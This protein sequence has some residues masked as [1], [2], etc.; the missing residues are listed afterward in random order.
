MTAI[1][2]VNYNKYEDTLACVDS[3]FKSETNETYHIIVVDN[4]S[5]NDSWKRL[6]VLNQHESISLLL[7]DDNRGYCAGNNIGIKYALE[8]LGADY[9]WILNPDTLVE[10]DTLQNLHDFAG[11]KNDLGI[12]GCKLVYY[13]DT[14]YLQALG[15]GDFGVHKY[16]ELRPGAH[17]Y[18]L[19]SSDIDLPDEVELDLI[20]GASM[21]IPAKIFQTCGLMNE[22][23]HLY[24]D[25][26]EFCLRV[27]K[28]GFRHYAISSAVVYHKEGWR[29]SG[30]KLM[31]TYY[32]SRNTL[33]LIKE[34]F[35]DY[36]KRNL[37]ISW[38][39]IFNYVRRGKFKFAYMQ[40]R[41]ICDFLHGI[42]GRVDLNIKEKQS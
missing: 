8:N 36:L 15:G 30:Q 14:Q 39:R 12:L 26:T 34:L 17:L 2:I 18:H 41:G 29:Q 27:A 9:I 25:E 33:Y 42:D 10:P 7:A 38:C 32:N 35:P 4:A 28:F 6:Q 22:R 37:F 11:T 24:A 20:I 1:V 3:I 19:K 31:G 13:P 21:Y 16:G 40:Y 23:F 5:P